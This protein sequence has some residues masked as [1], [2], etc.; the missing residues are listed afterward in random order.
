MALGNDFCNIL[1]PWIPCGVLGTLE[2]PSTRKPGTGTI[3]HIG[4]KRCPVVDTWWQTET[5]G[6][7]ISPLAGITPTKPSLPTLHLPRHSAAILDEKGIEIPERN[8][9]GIRQCR[10][11]PLA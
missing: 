10:G 8:S 9:E 11:R 4:K 3:E 6:I 2:N 1:M 5:G 7:L